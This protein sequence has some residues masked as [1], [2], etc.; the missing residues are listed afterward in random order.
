MIANFAVN[1]NT[2]NFKKFD[3]EFINNA[4]YDPGN[5]VII[6]ISNIKE[7]LAMLNGNY[8]TQTSLTTQNITLSPTFDYLGAADNASAITYSISSFLGQRADRGKVYTYFGLFK[9][10][11]VK[12]IAF[13]DYG[14]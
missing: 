5:G 3:V 1:L 6:G 7:A 9:D 14:G 4:T 13:G 8:V 11:F 2:K 12:A 10:K